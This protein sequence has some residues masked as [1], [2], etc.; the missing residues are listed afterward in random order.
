MVIDCWKLLHYLHFPIL[1]AANLFREF[2]QA[3]TIVAVF[4][5]NYWDTT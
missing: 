4:M 3:K 1:Y 5:Q 2:I